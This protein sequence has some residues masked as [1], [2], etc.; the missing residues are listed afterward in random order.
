MTN[1]Y[2]R[3]GY[4]VHLHWKQTFYT[5]LLAVFI[6]IVTSLLLVFFKDWKNN[7]GNEKQELAQLWEDAVYDKTFSLSGEML[8]HKPMD[9]FLLIVRGFSAYQIAI[10]QIND[11]NTQT[12]IDT[13]IW[14]LRKALLI[15]KSPEDGRIQY[16]L[17]KA[18][19][20]KGF[21]YADLAVQ[22]LEE[23]KKVA[24]R[25]PDIPEYL[26]LAYATLHDYRNSVASFTLALNP[27]DIEQGART[28][29]E[30][31]NASGQSIHDNANDV[32]YPSDLLFLAIARSYIE[33]EE[34]EAAHAYL[35]RCV[36]TSRDSKRIMAARLLMGEILRKRGDIRGAEQQYAAILNEGGENAEA[37]YQLGELYAINND[38]IRARAEWRKAVAID[39]AHRQAQIRINSKG[40]QK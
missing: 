7:F 35:M 36:E 19:Y 26:G 15:K 40:L 4:G 1:T 22:F 12:Y 6:V 16:V 31:N 10:A 3:S 37:H 5:A 21:G 2:S 9:H 8:A 32:M 27:S 20:Y 34:L 28:R 38:P 33:L 25:A 24:Y 30:R 11:Y 23:A 29:N 39:P 14:S 13:C 18:Y 17:G